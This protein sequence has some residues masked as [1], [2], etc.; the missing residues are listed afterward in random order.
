MDEL[1]AAND[2]SGSTVY[3]GE[4]LVLPTQW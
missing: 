3:P 2:L 1:V 4:E